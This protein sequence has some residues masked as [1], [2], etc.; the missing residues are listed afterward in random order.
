MTAMR[1]RRDHQFQSDD[2]LM[3]FE[4]IPNFIELAA[5][6]FSLAD[7]DIAGQ[8]YYRTHTP[9]CGIPIWCEDP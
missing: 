2:E 7:I 1:L 3:A 9:N 6:A 8:I 4:L 5:A